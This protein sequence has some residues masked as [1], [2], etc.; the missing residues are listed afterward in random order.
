MPEGRTD[1]TEVVAL[2]MYDDADTEDVAVASANVVDDADECG[3][4]KG[5]EVLVLS[6]LVLDGEGGKV[7]LPTVEASRVDDDT[8]EPVTSVV[9]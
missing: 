1:V 9:P 6:L 4:D 3:G 5:A 8:V 2:A 7:L